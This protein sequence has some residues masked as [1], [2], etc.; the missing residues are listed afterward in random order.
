MM[1]ADEFGIS[2]DTRRTSPSADG[3]IHWEGGKLDIEWPIVV[4]PLVGA[5]YCEFAFFRI[6]GSR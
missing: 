5:D 6:M 3:S 2:I 1:L 4:K